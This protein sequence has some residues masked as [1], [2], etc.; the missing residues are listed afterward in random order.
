[1]SADIAVSTLAE[2][3]LVHLGLWQGGPHHQNILIVLPEKRKKC[4]E[5]LTPT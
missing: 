5:D 4:Q 3:L 2:P 1:V